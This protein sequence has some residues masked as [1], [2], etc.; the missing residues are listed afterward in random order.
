V[1]GDRDHRR[2]AEVEIIAIPDVGPQRSA[3]GR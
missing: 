3:S 2:P 1:V